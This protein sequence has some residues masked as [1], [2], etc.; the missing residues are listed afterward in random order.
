[1][2]KPE[3]VTQEDRDLVKPERKTAMNK[4][5]IAGLIEEARLDARDRLCPKLHRRTK[6]MTEAERMAA[7]LGAAQK[8]GILNLTEEW[9]A[10]GEH[11]AM[12]RLWHR[13]DI[14]Q[15]IDHKHRTDDCWCLRPIG[16]AVRKVLERSNDTD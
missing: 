5:E 4:D 2:T 16:L 15:L 9:G 11:Q 6:P 1:M 3:A 8:R 10:S 13:T 14:R 7:K 12:K